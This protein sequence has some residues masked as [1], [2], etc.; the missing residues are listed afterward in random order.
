MNTKYT[1]RKFLIGAI[2]F[3]L[4]IAFSMLDA[5]GF[6]VFPD[7]LQGLLWGITVTWLVTEG[8]LDYKKIKQ[9]Q[10]STNTTTVTTETL[11]PTDTIP[12]A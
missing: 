11:P 6:L 7:L 9:A 5:N 12:S 10:T 3:V 8:V 4:L 1:E 2:S